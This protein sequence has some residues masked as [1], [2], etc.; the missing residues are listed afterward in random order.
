[1]RLRAP[2]FQFRFWDD[3]SI[4]HVALQRMWS[5][6]CNSEPVQV[7]RKRI[8]TSSSGVPKYLYCLYPPTP[9]VNLT[10]AESRMTLSLRAS[11]PDSP[12]Q[13]QRLCVS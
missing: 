8:G 9:G 11:Y 1:M 13:L 5:A 12:V 2:V 3:H 4:G 6:A 7:S 10:L